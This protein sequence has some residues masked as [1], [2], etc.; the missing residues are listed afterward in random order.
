MAPLVD[1]AEDDP[2]HC[3]AIDGRRRGAVGEKLDPTL[4]TIGWD[5]VSSSFN[6]TS[7]TAIY[8]S[9]VGRVV[10]SIVDK[11][12]HWGKVCISKPMFLPPGAKFT[13]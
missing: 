11:Q 13:P 3:R 7:T 9:P 1:D 10:F 12:C 6:G 2:A 5:R 4:K 8:G